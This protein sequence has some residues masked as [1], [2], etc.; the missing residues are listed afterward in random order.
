MHENLAILTLR[1]P[2]RIEAA[3]KAILK[4]IHRKKLEKNCFKQT[5]AVM[6]PIFTAMDGSLGARY[7]NFAQ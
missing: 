3:R 7:A 5:T 6:L 4:T 2:F 1:K